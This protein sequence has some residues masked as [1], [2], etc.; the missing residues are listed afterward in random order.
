MPLD[1]DKPIFVIEHCRDC[2]SHEW[3]TRHDEAKYV[4]FA[5]SVSAEIL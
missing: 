3:N 1:L 2:K 5:D 4:G